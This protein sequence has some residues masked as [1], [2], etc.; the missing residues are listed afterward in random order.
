MK[1]KIKNFEKLKGK[2]WDDKN[3]IEDV[4]DRDDE[5]VFYV[6]RDGM[7]KI[8]VLETNPIQLNSSAI[9]DGIYEIGLYDTND[10]YVPQPYWIE[11]SQIDD[12]DTFME[13]LKTLTD[14][15]QPKL[16]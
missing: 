5:Y 2:K 7:R 11:L 8:I 16:L 10:N 4:R 13:K 1:L 15:W 6:W 3:F 14:K 9:S 12:I